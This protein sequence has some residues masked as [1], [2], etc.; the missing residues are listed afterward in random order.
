[1]THEIRGVRR[2]GAG[3]VRFDDPDGRANAWVSEEPM[4]AARPEDA[5]RD[6]IVHWRTR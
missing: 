2:D 3:F 6:R 4:I 1:M 5:A